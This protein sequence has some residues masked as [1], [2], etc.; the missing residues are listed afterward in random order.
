MANDPIIRSIRPSGDD[1][2]PPER[3][4][5]QSD[6]DGEPDTR[7]ILHVERGLDP[8]GFAVRFI[9]GAI[10]GA[11]VGFIWYLNMIGPGPDM[12]LTE[13]SDYPHQGTLCLVYVGFGA[14]IGGLGIG[15]FWPQHPMDGTHRL[16]L[17]FMGAVLVAAFVIPIYLTTASPHARA[18]EAQFE[19]ALQLAEGDSV[20]DM[21]KG[22]ASFEEI[23]AKY[24]NS[25]SGERAERIAPTLREEIRDAKEAERKF[26]IMEK[27]RD[28]V[29][30][31]TAGYD[32]DRVAANYRRIVEEHPNSPAARRALDRAEE[33]TALI[34]QRAEARP[35][36]ESEAPPPVEAPPRR[37]PEEAE[38]SAI[39]R[40]LFE[41]DFN[42]APAEAWRIPAGTGRTVNQHGS[43]DFALL[44]DADTVAVLERSFPR[45]DERIVIEFDY[46]ASKGAGVHLLLSGEETV[47]ELAGLPTGE[48][49]PPHYLVLILG[50]RRLTLKQ[51]VT[52]R[53]R[54]RVRIIADLA[55]GR[56]QV[57]LDDAPLARGSM[58]LNRGARYADR[59]AFRT[60]EGGTAARLD[61]IRLTEERSPDRIP[62]PPLQADRDADAETD[63]QSGFYGILVTKQG[64]EWKGQIRRQEDGYAVTLPNGGRLFF[65]DAMVKDVREQ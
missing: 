37:P 36:G 47:T 29:L 26:K 31:G 49:G 18:L 60:P 43:R 20:A 28:G 48:T 33:I 64:K 34:G 51:D 13:L 35:D 50:E 55:E 53:E 45:V 65:P 2:R 40:L 41:E 15:L 32:A 7:R 22:L 23:A 38:D 10:A 39:S 52:D 11:A 14:L 27:Y 46:L 62:L 61:N 17:F 25:S 44:A 57:F 8:F 12:E 9:C 59:I 24:P 5:P 63:A 56:Q 1:S 30:K 19:E 58:P 4:A 3:P 21:E 42:A 16:R 6:R 54:H